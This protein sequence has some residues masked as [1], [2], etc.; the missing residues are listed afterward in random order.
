MGCGSQKPLTRTRVGL[1]SSHVPTAHATCLS[2]KNMSSAH[3]LALLA[4][5]KVPHNEH[6][7]PRPN[8]QTSQHDS[9]PAKPGPFPCLSQ[10]LT[11][12]LVAPKA[13]SNPLPSHTQ[14]APRSYQIHLLLLPKV[15]TLFLCIVTIWS[16]KS[17]SLA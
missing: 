11:N 10:W 15:L 7:C 8:S 17:A 2:P 5:S 9:L 16:I 6:V 12:L 3:L 14:S 1:S 13:L 4:T